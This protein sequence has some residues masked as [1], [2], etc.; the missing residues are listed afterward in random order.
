MAG[1][2]LM[3]PKNFTS[4]D[5][6]VEAIIQKV[7]PKLVVGAPLG[8]G[9]PNHL[10]NTLYRR[11]ARDSSL[12]LRLVTA[13]SLE[14]PKAKSELERRFLDPFAARVFGDYPELE[15]MR[16]LRDG[17]LAPNVELSE[18][19]FKSGSMLGIPAAQQ[20][21]I[22][23][24]Y[25]HVARDMLAAGANV[26]LQAVALLRF[27]HRMHWSSGPGIGYIVVLASMAVVGVAALVGGHRSIVHSG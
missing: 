17:R 19:Y 20:H 11:V 26:V 16:D 14:R 21:Y 4:P 23:S 27:A 22:S 25:T 9:K 8:I 6:C 10:V 1:F 2:V 15:Y 24:N 3:A 13:L 18:F 5:D 12:H 7:G